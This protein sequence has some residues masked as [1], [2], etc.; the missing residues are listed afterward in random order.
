VLSL[1]YL[2]MYVPL[3]DLTHEI[4]QLKEG[5]FAVVDL[6]PTFG[7]MW[8]DGPRAGREKT[9]P[10]WKDYCTILIDSSVMHHTGV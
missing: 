5:Y 6:K 9:D 10:I 1:H 3:S 8:S 7:F 4:L 2:H